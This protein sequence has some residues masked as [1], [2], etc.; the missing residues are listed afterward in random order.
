M[1]Q[2]RLTRRTSSKPLAADRFFVHVPVR[3]LIRSDP[4]RKPVWKRWNRFTF[5]FYFLALLLPTLYYIVH[6]TSR[7][8]RL[9]YIRIHVYAAY[10]SICVYADM[11]MYLCIVYCWSL[12]EAEIEDRKILLH[13]SRYN[14]NVGDLI[15]K[16]TSTTTRTLAECEHSFHQEPTGT[17]PKSFFWWQ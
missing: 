11:H 1:N 15:T 9:V 13:S 5:I 12:A 8:V 3:A 14:K 7:R 6:N 17:A 2:L 10:L 16:P 4:I